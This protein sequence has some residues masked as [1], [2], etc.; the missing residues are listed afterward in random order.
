[1]DA[2]RVYVPLQ[3]KMLV[4]LNRQTG[5]VAWTSEVETTLA[6]VLSDATV[7]VAAAGQVA[8]LDAETGETRWRT[9]FER[10]LVGGLTSSIGWLI[11]ITESGDLV[12]FRAQ[13][14]ALIWQ[15]PL[16]T[17]S[18][19]APVSDGARA[20]VALTDGRVVGVALGDGALL[21]E[22]SL[23]GTLSAPTM[24][25]DRVFVGSDT[26]D[27]FAL[28]PD[29]GDIRWRWRAGGDVIGADAD[30]HGRV[31]FASL[32]NLLRGINQG[33][34]NQRWRKEIPSRPTSPPRVAGD[35]VLVSSVAPTITSYSAS[36]G[37]AA[38]T[39]AAPGE[40]QGPPLVDPVLHPFRVAMVVVTRDGRAA[41][42]IPTAMLFRE[43]MLNPLQQLPGVRLGR[44]LPPAIASATGGN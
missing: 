40:L 30:V 12:A 42:V 18:R 9:P 31:F 33:N 7:L 3:S 26:N 8:G 11:G 36:T 35:V 13:D 16:G 38:G 37:A 39:Y 29:S 21:W 2:T 24:T 22:R 34:G 14:G 41:G 4:A 32:D 43:P 1:M 19:Y 28:A 20:V 17:A 27:F 23:P 15:R 5:V 25:P 6:P 10:T 44:E